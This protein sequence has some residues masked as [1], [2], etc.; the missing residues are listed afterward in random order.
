MTEV[1]IRRATMKDAEQIVKKLIELAVHLKEFQQF[2]YKSD[3]S[4]VYSKRIKKHLLH[5]KNFILVAESKNEI[6]G[7]LVASYKKIYAE[8]EVDKFGYIEEIIISP[9][10]RGLGTGKKL[11]EKAGKIFK[12]N[13]TDY[14]YLN[15]YPKNKINAKIY[16]KLGFEEFEISMVKKI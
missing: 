13:S 10:K 11:M 12:Q 1:T 4:E 14:F 2:K 5:G 16:K 3:F 6:V 7:V 15:N 9:D 8:L